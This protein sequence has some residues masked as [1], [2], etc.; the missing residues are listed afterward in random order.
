LIR[1]LHRVGPWQNGDGF[2]VTLLSAAFASLVT[3]HYTRS[4]Y[5]GL[6]AIWIAS[7]FGL[8]R[9]FRQ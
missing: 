9:A 7:A 6:G 1:I 3:E 4:L 2:V 5:A 8:M